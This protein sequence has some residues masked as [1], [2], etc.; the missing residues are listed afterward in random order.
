MAPEYFGRRSWELVADV[1]DG[2]A[3]DDLSD[4]VCFYLIKAFYNFSPLPAGRSLLHSAEP[5]PTWT[6][7]PDIT[8]LKL[9][10]GQTFGVSSERGWG[11]GVL[12]FH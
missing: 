8:G 11:A 2:K 5:G 7:Y 12:C 4:A 1:T 10:S 6:L 9:N 3:D